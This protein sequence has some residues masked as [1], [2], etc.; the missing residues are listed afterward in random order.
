MIKKNKI[1]VDDIVFLY[2]QPVENSILGIVKMIYY[3]IIEIVVVSSKKTETKK[4]DLSKD[5]IA[6]TIIDDKKLKQCFSPAE[7]KRIKKLQKTTAIVDMFEG[8]Y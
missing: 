7:R 2:A 6:L 5:K 1:K 8:M 4:I 3:P